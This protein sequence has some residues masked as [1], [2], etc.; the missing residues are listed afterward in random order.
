MTQIPRFGA[1]S[2]VLLDYMHLVLLGVLKKNN[3]LWLCGTLKIRLA[4]NSIDKISA[5]LIELR[6]SQPTDFCRRPRSLRDVKFWKAI[7]FR[8]FLLYSG[9]I[10]L[11]NVLTED[12]YRNFMSLHVAMTILVS[13]VFIKI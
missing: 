3:L 4:E 2:N 6:K 7:E 10:V 13:P 1:I 12:R 5:K 9:P 11:K 8:N